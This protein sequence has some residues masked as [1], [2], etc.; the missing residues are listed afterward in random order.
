M[1]EA[2]RVP[3]DRKAAVIGRGGRTREMIEKATRTQ[4]TV[5]DDVEIDGE[6][7]LMVLMAKEM[8]TAIGRGFSAKDAMKLRQE[9][10]ELR[11]ISL[12]GEN[13]RKR[14][15]LFGRVIGR[16]GRSRELIEKETGASLCVRGK[17][18]CMIGTPEELD[19]AQ[20]AVEKLLQG[21]THAYAYK[22]MKIRKAG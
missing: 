16:E 7:V 13:E 3:D 21:K 5:S 1:I 10:C 15:R 17:T 22:R 19:P 2:V 11:T 20:E 12:E 8:V 18:L 6:D 14:K 4:I 9:G